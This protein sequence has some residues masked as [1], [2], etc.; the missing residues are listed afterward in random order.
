MKKVMF[1]FAVLMAGMLFFTGC[2]S[3][4]KSMREP[5]A[6]VEFNKSDFEFSEQLTATATSTTIFNIDWQRIFNQETGTVES[7]SMVPFSLVEIPVIGTMVFDPTANYALWE[8]MK[9]N[10]GYDVVFYPQFLIKVEKP[11]GIGFIY[12]QTTVTTT[13][14][15]AKI[16]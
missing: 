4:N 16:K 7:P 13:A 8:L 1:T 5:N 6:R 3:V 9:A 11:L 10:P 12:K 14:R 15:L 2:T